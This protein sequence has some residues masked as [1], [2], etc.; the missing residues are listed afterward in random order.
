MADDTNRPIGD[1]REGDMVMAINPDGN[2]E[3]RKVLK[4]VEH[5]GERVVSLNGIH[6]TLEH[7]FHLKGG[8]IKEL[9]DIA[10]SESLIAADG[11]YIEDWKT[12]SVPGTFSVYTLD[13]EYLHSFVAGGFRVN[14]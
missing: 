10:P 4:L 12:E 7:P 13:V 2:F 1:I 6:V 3:P 8:C 11:S 5:T 9:K 14:D